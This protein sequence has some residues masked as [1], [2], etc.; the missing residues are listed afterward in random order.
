MSREAEPSSA[1]GET[2]SPIKRALI[3][4]RELRARVAQLES[5]AH[6]PVAIIGAG[7][8]LPGAV[9][10]LPSLW[11]LLSEGRSGITGIPSDRWDVDAWFDEDA[12]APGRM[13]TRHGG[14]IDQVDRFD[15]AFFGIAPREAETMD[16]QQRLLLETTWHALE[17][18][19][20]A[21]DTLAG[22]R[23]GVFIGLA[24]NDHG[25]ALLADRE[26][27]DA[28]VSTGNAASVAGGRL[29]YVLGA[30]GPN[31]TVDTACSS[32]LVALHLAVQSLRRGECDLA[33]VGGV[34]LILTPEVHISF[35]RGR[36]LARDGRC[37]TF[38][39]QA[40]GY[41]RSEGCVVVVLRRAGDLRAG[42]RA[43]ALVRG[44]AINQDGRSGGLTAPNGPAQ[45]A[46]IAAALAD[47]RVAATDVGY[48]EAHGTGTPLGDPIEVHALAAAL[49]PGRDDAAPLRVGSIKTNIGHLEAAAGL[50]GL[51]KV[52]LALEHGQ[53]PP[54]LNFDNPSSQID[55]ACCPQLQVPRQLT[56]WSP[57][58]G[59]RVAGL[60]SFGFSG[61]NAH[62]ILEQAARS[63]SPSA[64]ESFAPRR[65]AVLTLSARDDTALAELA[66]AMAQRLED[67][68]L[69]NDAG[70]LATLAAHANTARA[71][72]PRRLSVRASDAAAMCERLR[73]AA[74]GRAAAGVVR[75]QQANAGEPR[76]AFLF[77]GGGAQSVGM[78]MQLDRCSNVFRDKLDE[79]AAIL[80][81]LL[82]RPL[83]EL[84]LAPG[85]HD[86]PIHQTRHGQPALVAVE[87]ALAA[88]WDSWGIKPA[89]VLGHSLGEYAA[90][91][92]AGV[93]TL[94]DALRIVVERTRQVD[95]LQVPGAMAVVFEPAAVVEQH[96]AAVGGSLAIGAYNGPEQVVVSG[97]AEQVEALVRQAEGRGVR[98]ARLRVAYASHSALMEPVLDRFERSI[99]DVRHAPPHM[100]LI[101]NVSGGV[102][103]P[104]LLSGARYWRDHLRQ[105][106]RFDAG[107]RTLHGLGMTHF[108]EIGPHPVL[109]GMAAACLPPDAG[110]WLPSL[111][112][113]E[114]DWSVMLESLQTLYAAG[115]AVD[116]SGFEAGVP[117]HRVDLPLYPFQRR[118]YWA[119]GT[120]SAT[121]ESAA[122]TWRSMT[123]AL[124]QE[125]ERAPIGATLDG[126]AARWAALAELARAHATTV[127]RAAGLFAQAGASHTVAE[128]AAQ[129]GAP[130]SYR[131]LLVRWLQSLADGG[132][133]HAE[134]N[135]RY[136]CPAALPDPALEQVTAEA[137]RALAD[138]Q[139]LMDYVMHCGRLLGSV[140]RGETS[141]LET[142]FP[143]GEFTLADGL[144]RRSS[145]MRYV[146]GLAAAAVRA[147]VAARPGAR[148]SVL[149]AGAGTGGTTAAVLAALP[150]D[151]LR[152]YLFT[153]ASPFFFE[154]ARAEF[155]QSHGQALAFATLDLDGD[156]AAQGLAGKQFDLVLASNAVHAARD[157][158][159]ALA[160]LRALTAPGGM[161]LLIESTTHL[162]WFD[163]T[164]GLIEGWQHFADDDLRRDHP[165]L[166]A[167][168]WLRLLRETG[169]DA[170][171]A[172]PR[173][174]SAAAEI[175]QHVLLARAAGERVAPPGIPF[176]VDTA[177]LGTSGPSA[178]AVQS[179]PQALRRHL[180]HALP[181]ERL[182]LLSD[183]VRERV[184]QAMKLAPDQAPS[185]DQRLKDLGFDSL[186]AVQMRNRL[187]ADL[188]LDKPLP[189]TLMFDHPTI[190]A[191]ARYL[192]QRLARPVAATA[193]RHTAAAVVEAS[194]PLNAAE[195]AVLSDAE[196]EALLAARLADL[197]RR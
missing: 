72:L 127:L 148:L 79:A 192:D 181:S 51:L 74:A 100:T 62:V 117:R 147:L 11:S 98:V 39:A 9:N 25:R 49:G 54:H 118:R 125:A 139:P 187:G 63:D 31:V 143:G 50:A 41:V 166:D 129:L 14:F 81:P 21:P 113:D 122:H 71:H 176:E 124:A 23:T 55:W 119:L 191:L 144:Y 173:D 177:A 30:V 45:E 102:A 27:V 169:F 84:I 46:V 186:M 77:S 36:M 121:G 163:I 168:A 3:E 47:A 94:H 130:A 165:L 183:V 115:A 188:G 135:E 167:P 194:A 157:L 112:R 28:H 172:W 37:K 138:N 67:P 123:T 93:L 131:H 35:S 12:D 180:E 32:S 182:D 164:T 150:S 66:T 140:L 40:D 82:G 57:L 97:P 58:G 33:L 8:R 92:V 190:D 89:A 120:I 114:G 175:G 1:A 4:I 80:D 106:V 193:E 53:I 75:S 136:T 24:N 18:A 184:M 5:A 153:D 17:D 146:N 134:G 170:A 13:F 152:Q 149:E 104:A 126:Y 103:D 19:G 141:P 56:P 197:A 151:A 128:V 29:S 185:R 22:S 52:M 78:A 42:E 2:L 95:A 145:T 101:S 109:L 159:G 34:N 110:T 88:M 38:D 154:R 161:L 20:I 96:I 48:V 158:R 105:P 6:A 91:H 116:W 70:A 107:M 108:I 133:L 64:P 179:D 174:G 90:A 26:H 196:I 16:P 10:D 15:A 60:S 111:Q 189:A 43:R 132:A 86:A 142:L 83:R 44:S 160:R 61:T 155:G 85:E 178:S 65:P 137:Q 171:Q 76:V 156:L 195:V 73:A 68:R 69:T 99:A 59:R 162:A 7:A 87:I